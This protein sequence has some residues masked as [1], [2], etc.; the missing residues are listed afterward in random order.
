MWWFEWLINITLLSF[1]LN[2]INW[3]NPKLHAS[4]VGMVDLSKAFNRVSHQLVIEDL[5]DMH[6]PAWLLMILISYLTGRSMVLKFKGCVSTSR[7]LPGSSPQG[8]FLGV[9][10][11]IIKFNGVCLRPPIPR[12]QLKK[13]KH[14]RPKSISLKFVDDLSVGVK[15]DLSKDIVNETSVR[16]LPL[17]RHK[18]TGHILPPENNLLQAYMDD[19]Q[20]F[21]SSN[22]LVIN[23]KKTTIMLFNVASTVD[24]PPELTI[25]DSDL[26]KVVE[27]T[28]LLGIILTSNLKWAANTSNICRKATSQLWMLRRM[29]RMLVD[30]LVMLDCYKKEIRCHLELGVACWHSG[31]TLHQAGCIERIQKIAVTIILNEKLDYYLACCILE[32]EPLS[33][34]REDICLRFAEKTVTESR[35]KDLFK[36]TLHYKLPRENNIK[37]IEPQCNKSR[38]FNS[39]LPYLTRRLNG[40]PS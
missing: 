15:V 36:P 16:P 9:F 33:A 19:L 5:F 8:T 30:P 6:V 40:K 24:F 11:F 20:E 17:I 7:L 38:M 37:F 13:P 39:P 34:R 3:D 10:L 31:L 18:V 29:K 35:H 28:K 2:F 21:C 25:G 4:L 23:E 32:I 22:Q 27:E 26:L 1:L 14:N 12:N